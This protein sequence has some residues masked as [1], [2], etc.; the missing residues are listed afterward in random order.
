MIGLWPMGRGPAF[1][2]INRISSKLRNRCDP[3]RE[4]GTGAGDIGVSTYWVM[5]VFK[6]LPC[7]PNSNLTSCHQ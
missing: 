5:R 4:P 1:E 2:D 3:H 7:G 6:L